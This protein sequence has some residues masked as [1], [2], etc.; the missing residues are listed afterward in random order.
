MLTFTVSRKAFLCVAGL[1]IL[2]LGAARA[3]SSPSCEEALSA[4][5]GA[6]AFDGDSTI[7][8][9]KVDQWESDIVKFSIVRPGLLVLAGE[10]SGTQAA[11][12]ATDPT[13]VTTLFVD[14]AEI[15]EAHPLTTVVQPGEHCVQVTPPAT[16]DLYMQATFVDVC[17]LGPQDD[18]GDSFLCA[19]PTG[20][21]ETQ[22]GTITAADHDLFSF[23][24]TAATSVSI[25]LSTSAALSAA[26]FGEDGSLAAADARGVQALDAGIYFI[27]IAGDGGAEGTYSLTVTGSSQ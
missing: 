23:S 17:G 13:S 15:G 16:G 11:I 22:S 27:S 10:D 26:L 25:D 4:P 5:G 12:W 2:S 21:G 8:L 24:L 20:L 14:G 1:F 18:H 9:D 3:Q 6:T 7:T 19:T